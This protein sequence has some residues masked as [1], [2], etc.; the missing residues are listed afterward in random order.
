MIRI[1]QTCFLGVDSVLFCLGVTSSSLDKAE[2][3][4]LGVSCTASFAKMSFAVV[5]GLDTG[6]AITTSRAYR[7]LHHP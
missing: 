2:E 1:S 5:V 6:V 3:V 4:G 7:P